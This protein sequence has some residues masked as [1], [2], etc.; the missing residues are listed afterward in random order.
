MA[1]IANQ[2][3]SLG[4][5]IEVITAPHILRQSEN[6]E[7][8]INE[9]KGLSDNRIDFSAIG[10]I[11]DLLNKARYD[12]LHIIN[13]EG[14]LYYQYAKPVGCTTR[15]ALSVHNTPILGSRLFNGIKNYTLER[16][17][18]QLALRTGV[19]D[20]FLANSQV[21]ANSLYNLDILQDNVSFIPFGID[22]QIF[23]PAPQ[24][25]EAHSDIRLL[26][27][28]RFIGR[29]GIEHLLEA[30][31]YLPASYKLTLTGSGNVHDTSMHNKLVNQAKERQ[32]RVTLQEKRVSLG[33][34]VDLYQ[35]ADI[36]VMPSEYEGFG[37][38]ALEAMACNIPVVAT[39]VQGL[40][41]FVINNQTGL[42]VEFG[43][44]QQLAMAIRKINEDKALRNMITRNAL[45]MTSEEHSFDTM[46]ERYEQFYEEI[47]KS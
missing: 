32:D 36:F 40:E 23:K 4:H 2:M 39:N 17:A 37:L 24:Q 33:Q 7:Y 21:F 47:V 27:T 38:G 9:V 28:S 10:A 31:D 45:A 34:L 5:E 29:K 14:L 15:T 3:S 44:P 1:T 41:E 35:R 43:N 8:S 6:F 19:I 11:S 42:T 25:N 16:R 26:C 18:V 46:I 20:K 12:I 30:M 22:T 13:Y